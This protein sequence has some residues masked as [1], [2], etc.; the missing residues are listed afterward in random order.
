MGLMNAVDWERSWQAVGFVAFGVALFFALLNWPP[1]QQRPWLIAALLSLAGLGLAVLGP[2]ILSRLPQEFLHFSDDLARSKP[3]DIFNA[4]ETINA[5]VLAGGL[6]LPIPLLLALSLRVDL[7]HR[8]WLPPLLLL[9]TGLLLAT[10]LLAQSRGAY[11]AVALSL[12]LVLTLRWPWA[13]LIFL[14]GAIA[15]GSVLSLEGMS[16]LVETVSNEGSISSLSGRW[17]IW[18][19]AFQAIR[20]FAVTGIGIGSFDLVIPQLY[21]YVEVRNVIP[22]AHNLF[23]QV[24]VDLGVPGLLFYG[25]LWGAVLWVFIT[26]LWHGGALASATEA[27]HLHRH[28]QRRERRR[29]RRQAALRWALAAGGLGATVAMFLHGLVDAVTWGTKLAFLP[30]LLVALAGT[31]ALPAQQPADEAAFD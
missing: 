30:W 1:L 10:L 9:P 21:P 13:G 4:G 2:M 24:G 3:A 29:L 28:D 31:L 5:N 27:E 14:V 23:L 16:A 20:D 7:A 11:L 19:R 8:H 17:E 26:I 18:S 12:L 22:H 25:W 15:A 6:L